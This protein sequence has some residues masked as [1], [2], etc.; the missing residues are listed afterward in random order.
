[1]KMAILPKAIY[2]FNTIPIKIPM[3]LITEWKINL[4]VHLEAQKTANREG[5]TEQKED[6]LQ[7]LPSNYA[8][9][10]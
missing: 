9:K 3:I 5:N 2:M 10:P 4:K 8:T 7:Y 6:V 1:V